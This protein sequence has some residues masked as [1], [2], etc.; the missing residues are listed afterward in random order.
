MTAYDLP[1]PRDPTDDEALAMFKAV[2]ELFPSKSL[3]EDKWYIL[4]V[5]SSSRSSVVDYGADTSSSQ[6][7]WVVACLALRPFFTKSSSSVPGIRLLN[8]DKL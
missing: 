4:T 8:N 6:L 7:W 2:E 3:G 1:I 5:S